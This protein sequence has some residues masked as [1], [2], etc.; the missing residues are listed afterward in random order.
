MSRTGLA[1][2][3]LGAAGLL[4]LGAMALGLGPTGFLFGL[5]LAI[6]PLPVYLAL[7][8]WLDRYEKEPR[9][10]LALAFLWGATGA[11][12]FAI[13]LNAVDGVLVGALAGPG[14]VSFGTTVLS[15]PVVEETAKASALVLL[16][17]WKRDEF[18]NV[19]DGVVYAGMVGLGF[20]ATENV[21][22]YGHALVESPAAPA[23]AFVMRG[24]LAPFSHPLFTSMVGIGLGLRR[25]GAG[26]ALG[27]AA[28]ALGL[29]VAILLHGIWNFSAALGATF[30][31]VYFLLMVPIF[32]GVLALVAASLRRERGVLREYLAPF[33]DRGLLSAGEL[34]AAVTSAGRWRGG[35][36]AWRAGGF[37]GWRRYRRGLQALGELAF[38][39]WRESR[40]LVSGEEAERRTAAL[41]DEVRRLR[42]PPVVAG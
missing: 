13:V 24:V 37:R 30:F 32:V 29:A 40:G 25:E 26:G 39:R 19:T 7:V 35:R 36:A 41:A 28:P 1:A 16:Y 8:L 42:R 21:G 14:A 20:A 15:A 6:L 34:E 31:V 23:A 17:L 38:H 9:G 33:V 12:L 3:G 5:G 4:V 22:Y 27:R 2:V 10:A 11:V 18:D